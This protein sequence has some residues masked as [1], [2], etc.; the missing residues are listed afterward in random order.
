M[1]STETASP[2]TTG[3][4]D[5]CVT[6]GG[7]TLGS[8]P[9]AALTIA[10]SGGDARATYADANGT[11]AFDVAAFAAEAGRLAAPAT[12]T[13]YGFAQCAVG[14]DGSG[15]PPDPASYPTAFTST[16]GTLVTTAGTAFL[17]ATGTETGS[18]GS[19]STDAAATYWLSCS[20][21]P[22]VPPTAEAG[23]PPAFPTGT[24][25]CTSGITLDGSAVSENLAG[26]GTL[27]LVAS[28]DGISATYGS[29]TFLSGAAAFDATSA[30]TA[31]A[32]AGQTLSAYC[33]ALTPQAQPVAQPFAVTAG[34]LIV[35][36]ATLFL[37]F[38]GAGSATS[39]CPVTS[40][41]GALVCTRQP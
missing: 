32:V 35:D 25:A 37:A 22:D 27:T 18:F 34:A 13:D 17:A 21:G 20:G 6:A 15:L 3:T 26:S 4:Y 41:T 9:S 14:G 1:P 38:V 16:A 39:S 40:F 24:Y 36:G 19:C 5:R 23:A 12:V 11:V 33:S 2:P 28:G 8:D 10:G 7:D 29:D 31:V 30:T